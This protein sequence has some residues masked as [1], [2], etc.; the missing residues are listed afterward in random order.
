LSELSPPTRQQLSS[1]NAAAAQ[2]EKIVYSIACGGTALLLHTL[3]KT[4][5]KTV[6]EFDNAI[7]T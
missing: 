6:L 2:E 5:D 7:L 3:G 1:L 4:L